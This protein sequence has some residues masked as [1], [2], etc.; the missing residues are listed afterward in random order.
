MLNIDLDWKSGASQVCKYIKIKI[1]EVFLDLM[2]TVLFFT[3]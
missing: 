2:F 3:K 1:V